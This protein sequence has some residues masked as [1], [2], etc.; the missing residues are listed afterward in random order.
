MI[1]YTAAIAAALIFPITAPAHAAAPAS[2]ATVVAA[3]RGTPAAVCPWG[4]VDGNNWSGCKADQWATGS[5]DALSKCKKVRWRL[6][7][8]D[9]KGLRKIHVTPC[10]KAWVVPLKG[11]KTRPTSG[12]PV[13]SWGVRW[14]GSGR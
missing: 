4:R 9:L 5:A 2:A 6:V 14:W 12:R 3:K 13:L 10:Q 11:S 8:H 1:A 7:H